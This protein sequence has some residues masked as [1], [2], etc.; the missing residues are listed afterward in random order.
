MPLSVHYYSGST[1]LYHSYKLSCFL[2]YSDVHRAS[3]VKSDVSVLHYTNSLLFI[4]TNRGDVIVFSIREKSSI[5]TELMSSPRN[6][7]S[8]KKT[9]S[10]RYSYRFVT[11]THLSQSP[12]ASIHTKLIS[13]V[14]VE[15]V[16][17]SLRQSTNDI[18]VL[19]VQGGK[20]TAGHMYL[21]ELSLSPPNSIRS[22]PTSS[23]ASDCTVG[24]YRNSLTP[25]RLSVVSAISDYTPL[26]N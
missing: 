23:L 16:V 13:N 14:V 17:E 6:H 24:S 21:F 19:V 25:R 4:G 18:H 8:V 12:I 26:K 7:T 10:P 3:I 20:Q 15:D 11:N 9:I 22:S 1:L 5:S 2:L